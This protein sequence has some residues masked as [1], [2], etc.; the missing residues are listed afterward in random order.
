MRKEKRWTVC[1]NG[2]GF[3]EMS[4]IDDATRWKWAQQIWL[5]KWKKRKK[6]Y[7]EKSWFYIS[8]IWPLVFQDEN[9]EII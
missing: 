6:Y 7:G 5:G 8:S 4:P 9:L 2:Q 3:K 1:W